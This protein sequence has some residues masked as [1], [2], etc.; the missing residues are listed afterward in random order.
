MLKDFKFDEVDDRYANFK[1]S[2]LGEQLDKIQRI[3]QRLKI[4]VLILVDGLESSGRGDVI[5]DLTR[6]LDP[7]YIRVEIFDEKRDHEYEHPSTWRFWQKIPNHQEIVVFDQSF[8]SQV[9]NRDPRDKAMLQRR[10]RELINFEKSLLENEII[11]LK[12][13][14]HISQ[15]TQAENIK[16]LED[17]NYRQYLVSDRDYDQN[18]NYEECIDWMDQVLKAT[19]IPESSWHLVSSE[20]RKLAAKTVLG[21]TIDGITAGI[22]RVTLDREREN[23]EGPAYNLE[24]TQL[25]KFDLSKSLSKQE[26]QDQLEDLQK[27]AADLVYECY[28]KEIAIVLAFE[29]VDAA[30]KG[31]AIKRLTRHIDPR[32]YRIYGIKAPT[33]LELSYHYLWR[34]QRKFPED[35]DM[36]IFDRSWYGRVL[37]ERIEGFASE[38]EWK[39]AYDEIN[40]ME[41]NLVDHGN[42]VMKFFVYIDEDEQK[43]RFIDRIEEPD[44]NYKITDEDWRNRQKW[45]EYIATYEEMLARTDT[46]KAPWYII[47]T[48]NKRYARIMVLKQ[49]IKHV[50]TALKNRKDD[51]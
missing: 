20:D 26:Y 12:F 24:E 44:K 31:G 18:D 4:P 43:Q 2:E 48:N 6:E 36:V 7:R 23:K 49:F 1:R 51:K 25:D 40:H 29:G 34:F 17:S 32:S 37:V 41:E 47:P 38:K 10:T 28:T 16:A 13:F 9:M 33:P 42:I 19:N 46:D 27:Q 22:E 15:E 5:N 50:E 21:L 30:G 8:Y 35:G 11:I 45:D 39:Q 3:V 14:L